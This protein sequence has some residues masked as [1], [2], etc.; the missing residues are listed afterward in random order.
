MAIKLKRFFNHVHISLIFLAIA[1]HIRYIR[2]RIWFGHGTIFDIP[3]K[4]AILIII[5]L[6][7]WMLV[8]DSEFP[9]GVVA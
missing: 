8:M 4:D 6:A 3:V 9:A 2:C 7:L 1:I 5:V